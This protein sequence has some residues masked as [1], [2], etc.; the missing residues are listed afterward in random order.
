MKMKTESIPPGRLLNGIVSPIPESLK[1]VK[2]G[3]SAEVQLAPF[4]DFPLHDG[5]R[6]HAGFI[7]HCDKAAFDAVVAAY[8]AGGRKDILVDFDHASE[9]GGKTAAAAW[10]G[11]L[12]VDPEQGLMGTMTFTNEGAEAVGGKTYR[13]LSV[14]WHCQ[15]DG[16][17]DELYSVGL[18]NRPNLPVRPV[19]NREG[20]GAPADP[21][22]NK[23]GN[24]DMDQKIL[25]ALGLGPDAT[26]DDAVAK[27]GALAK[28]ASDAKAAK[29]DQ[30]AETFCDKCKGKMNA[31]KRA[32]I[33]ALYLKSPELAQAF[34]N[35]VECAP[36]QGTEAAGGIDAK[37]AKAPSFAAAAKGGVT[38][39]NALETYRAMPAGRERSD[40]LMANRAEIERLHAE[41]NK[42]K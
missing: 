30:E 10:L 7:Q 20:G 28:E 3:D 27:I 39:K 8:G 13:Y 21:A 9:L 6:E 2:P 18:T 4:G 12:R 23:K 31:A 35:C 26:V 40:Y 19:V 11:A 5:L 14:C 29:A 1:G 41:E 32:E 17:P 22:A 38:A 37:N 36:A 16:R 25:T 24:T 42:S 15:D 33:K 34:L